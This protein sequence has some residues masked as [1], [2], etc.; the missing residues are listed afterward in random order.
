M[1]KMKNSMKKILIIGVF[2]MI[3]VC[4][5]FSTMSTNVA[6]G[7][8]AFNGENGGVCKSGISEDM[9]DMAG[10]DMGK[11]NKK[12]N[13]KINEVAVKGMNWFMGII[14]LVSVVTV[15]SGGQRFVT[16]A[17]EPGRVKQARMMIVFGVVG[18]FV[19]MIA[20]TFVNF[21]LVNTLK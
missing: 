19:S 20:F 2:L 1:D 5:V 17:G 7:V 6:A 21:I 8:N 16:S 4:A 14:G 13:K 11:K 18:L 10:C 15:I 9:K 3:S 12:N